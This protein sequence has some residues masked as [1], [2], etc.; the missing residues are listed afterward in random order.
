MN[1]IVYLIQDSDSRS[2][3]ISEVSDE[4]GC[5]L[6]PS[7]NSDPDLLTKLTRVKP[8]LILITEQA[9]Y[10]KENCDLAKLIRCFSQTRYIPLVIIRDNAEKD[11]F[12]FHYLTEPS[13]KQA[14]VK[15]F[16]NFIDLESI[17]TAQCVVA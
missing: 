7:L 13:E 3:I 5:E 8:N 14:V 4:L 2:E 9:R 10:A 1:N 17:E 6:I 11:R 15:V 12:K 16:E